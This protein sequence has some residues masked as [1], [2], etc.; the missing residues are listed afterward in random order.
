MLVRSRSN[1]KHSCL[2]LAVDHAC[3]AGICSTWCCVHCSLNSATWWCFSQEN[4]AHFVPQLFRQGCERHQPSLRYDLRKTMC[5]NP[6]SFSRFNGQP[7]NAITA[8]TIPQIAYVNVTPVFFIVS[9][10]ISCR[11]FAPNFAMLLRKH[12]QDEARCYACCCRRRR[13]WRCKI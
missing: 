1:R 4:Y 8:A 7:S 5:K 12:S 6:E 2:M 10:N 13:F 3:Q 11:V 9:H